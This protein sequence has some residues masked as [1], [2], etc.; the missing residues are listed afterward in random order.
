[1]TATLPEIRNANLSIGAVFSSARAICEQR[2]WFLLGVSVLAFI[3]AGVVPLVLQGPTMVGV[4]LCMRGI[5]RG[6]EVNMDTFSK[7][8]EKFVDSLLAALLLAL[9]GMAAAIVFLPAF[10]LFIAGIDSG[11]DGIIVLAGILLTMLV[12][13]ICAFISVLTTITFGL[14]AQHDVDGV[15]AIQLALKGCWANLLG[16]LKIGLAVMVLTTLGLMACII[17]AWLVL[18]L[19]YAM[20][21]VAVREIFQAPNDA[22]TVEATVS[23]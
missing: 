8:F 9:V 15:A 3:A 21:W 12:L 6:E 1:M 23:E 11:H 16:T 14:I 10:V 18:P 20:G 22:V 5:D 19:T 17:G 2:Y 4:M 7:G 13:P